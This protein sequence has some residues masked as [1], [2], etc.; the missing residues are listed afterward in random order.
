MPVIA[1]LDFLCTAQYGH[2]TAQGA[3]TLSRGSEMT[4][5]FE[6]AN[7]FGKEAFDSGLKSFAAV[8]KSAQAIAVE[9]SDFAKKSFEDGAAAWQNLLSAKSLEKAV[10]VQS[11]YAKSAY[12]S[13]VAE[14]TKLT[15]LYADMAKEAYKPFEEALAKAR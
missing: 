8:S 12:E 10:E 5:T 14:A 15:D 7:A 1:L 4:K 9:A 2:R 13:F 3:S 11:G 6:D